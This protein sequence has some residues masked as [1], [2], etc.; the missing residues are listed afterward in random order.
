MDSFSEP[1]TRQGDDISLDAVRTEIADLQSHHTAAGIPLS[2]RVLHVCHYLPVTA[3]LNSR[4][5]VLSPPPTPPIGP[6]DAPPKPDSVWTIGPRYGHAAMISGIQSLAATHTQLIIGWTGDILSPTHNEH[7]SV[8]PK[9]RAALDDALAAY[10]PKESDPDDD[11][12]IT[13]VP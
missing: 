5:G 6:V 10:Q 1:Y 8:D 7:V 2:G 12:K 4:P 3:T 9:D 11:R 13:Y